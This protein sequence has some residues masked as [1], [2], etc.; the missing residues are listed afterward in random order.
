MTAH[1]SQVQNLRRRFLVR[2]ATALLNQC[3]R[4]LRL[5]VINSNVGELISRRLPDVRIYDNWMWNDPHGWG[6]QVYPAARNASIH[7]NVIAETGSGFVVGGSANVVQLAHDSAAAGA[8]A[9]QMAA[10]QIRTHATG[11]LK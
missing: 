7:D 1:C 5:P 4:D 3:V 9:G 6:V 10:G 11:P 2:T 8:V